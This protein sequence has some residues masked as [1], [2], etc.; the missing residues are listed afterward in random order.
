MEPWDCWFDV[1]SP[2]YLAIS[3]SDTHAEA[4]ERYLMKRENQGHFIYERGDAEPDP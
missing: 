1:L 3:A 2:G 4:A